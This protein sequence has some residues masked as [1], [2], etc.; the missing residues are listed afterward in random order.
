MFQ[1]C[2][3]AAL[4]FAGVFLATAAGFFAAGFLADSALGLDAT[5]LAGAASARDLCDSAAARTVGVVVGQFFGFHHLQGRHGFGAAN[6]IR[7]LAKCT[8]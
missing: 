1:E 5:F 2:Y 4:F 6:G 7:G 8:A 3:L